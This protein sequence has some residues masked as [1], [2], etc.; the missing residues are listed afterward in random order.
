MSYVAFA[1]GRDVGVF[2]SVNKIDFAMF[3]GLT[4]GAND[5]IASLAPH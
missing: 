4:A 3:S 2:V 5:L 1:P